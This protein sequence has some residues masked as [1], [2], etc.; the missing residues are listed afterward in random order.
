M[1]DLIILQLMIWWL[2]PA[3]I[4]L[5]ALHICFMVVDKSW[6]PEYDVTTTKE[7]LLLT[8][9]WPLGAAIVILVIYTGVRD[10]ISEWVSKRVGK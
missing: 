2:T 5:T 1:S 3:A 4:V 10:I 9:I 7:T 8:A 6:A